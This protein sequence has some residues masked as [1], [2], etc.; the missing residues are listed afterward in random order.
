VNIAIELLE[1]CCWKYSGN[2]TASQLS[3]VSRR[4][5]GR[6]SFQRRLPQLDKFEVCLSLSACIYPANSPSAWQ[7]G[8]NW[9][10]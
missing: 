10:Q 8:A 5:R 9:H 2:T 3:K 1:E 6:K 7:R 4:N